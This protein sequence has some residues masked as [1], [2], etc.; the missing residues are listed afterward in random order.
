LVIGIK[1]YNKLFL[2]YELKKALNN[3]KVDYI[4]YDNYIEKKVEKKLNIK[5]IEF[6]SKTVCEKMSYHILYPPKYDANKTY[7]VLYMLHGLR[8]QAVFWVEKAKLGEIY[9]DM[10]EKGQI[11][12]MVIIL[13]ESGFEGRAWYSNWI[14][15]PN[16]R[17]EDYFSSE[18]IEHAER[19]IKVSKR[20]ISGFSM[21]GYGALKLSLKHLN[22]F[23]SVSSFAGAINFP[24]LF[25][26]ELKGLGLLKHMKTNRYMTKSDDSRHFARVFGQKMKFFRN[27]NVYNIL[28]KKV[29]HNLKE[30]KKLEFLLSVGEKDNTFYTMLYQWEDVIG[31]MEK[32]GLSYRGRLVKDAEHT[33]SYVE[34]ELPAILTF[35]SKS[36]K[37]EKND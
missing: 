29:K 14:S 8:D 12:E 18:L 20:G 30:L 22:L 16:R 1:L 11:E 3:T 25:I 33:W 7:P 35:H 15:N 37:G 13:P 34:R 27:E 4:N 10:L 28:R 36:F 9:Y 31:E 6:K 5:K 19:D 17:Y 23:S 2:R 32:R 26:T 21:G 24:R